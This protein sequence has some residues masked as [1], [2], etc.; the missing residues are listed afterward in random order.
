MPEEK[1]SVGIS[2]T[3]FIIG[4][5]AAILAASLLSTVIAMQWAIVQGP[6]GDRGDT[7]PQGEQGLQGPR[8]PAGPAGEIP[9]NATYYDPPPV[10]AYA[11]VPTH[12]ED[13]GSIQNVSIT[14]N[15]NSQLLIVFS[16]EARVPV[17]GKNVYVRAMVNETVAFPGDV[18]LTSSEE[19]GVCSFVFY[20]P[21]VG[22]GTYTVKMQWK[23]YEDFIYLLASEQT[24]TVVALPTQ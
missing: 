12:W 5:V 23:A 15:K 2:R 6:K 16:A 4:I 17:L 11:P 3:T 9:Y 22:A 8:G 7:G 19:H 24:L 14:L 10:P 21:N 1:E 20:L 13:M 18:I